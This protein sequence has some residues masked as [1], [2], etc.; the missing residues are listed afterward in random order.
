MKK[1]KR[2]KRSLQLAIPVI[3]IYQ[4][5]NDSDLNR[6]AMA[7]V[8]YA[9]TKLKLNETEFFDMMQKMKTDVEAYNKLLDTVLTPELGHLKDK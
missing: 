9:Y 3:Q 8:R 1:K 7:I 6:L 5:L 2:Y 4:D